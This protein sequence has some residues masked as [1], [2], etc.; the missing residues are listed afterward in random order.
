[1][2]RYADFNVWADDFGLYIT[3]RLLLYASSNDIVCQYNQLLSGEVKTRLD[4]SDCS[5]F[6]NCVVYYFRL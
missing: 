4:F 6:G 1:M 5:L 2:S 3:G